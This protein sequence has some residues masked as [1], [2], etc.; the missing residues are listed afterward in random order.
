M[1]DLV[2]PDYGVT[3]RASRHDR[4]LR[5]LTVIYPH[6]SSRV[7]NGPDGYQY[8]WKPNS[9]SSDIVVSVYSLLRAQHV[10]SW[11]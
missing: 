5:L 8:R 11:R 10:L 2:R 7:F 4:A 3:V 1:A 9:A 6:Q